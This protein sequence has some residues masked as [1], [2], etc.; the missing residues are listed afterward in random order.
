MA[1]TLP[2]GRHERAMQWWHLRSRREQLVIILVAAVAAIALLW[3]FVW[4]PLQRDTE[5]LAR[6]L[7]DGRAALAEARKQSDEIA[8]LARNAPAAPPGDARAAIE[9]AM[10]RQGLKPTGGI[11]RVGDQRWRT[12]FAAVSFDSLTA[13]IDGLQRDAGVRA[14]EVSVT[15]RV[16]PGQVRADVTLARD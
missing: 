5:R 11:E 12:T 3:A 10:S 16:E 8:G 2:V 7:S 4:Q 1:T 13:F 9:S 14:A 15:A 6:A